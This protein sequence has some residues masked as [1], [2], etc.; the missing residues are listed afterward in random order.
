[1]QK[2]ERIVFTIPL[3]WNHD[4]IDIGLREAKLG[5]KG[6]KYFD[7]DAELGFY[8]VGEFLDEGV[9]KLFLVMI[10]LFDELGFVLDI[11]LEVWLQFVGGHDFVFGLD[12]IFSPVIF[13]F[14][15]FQFLL[16]LAR[17]SLQY[18]IS[19]FHNL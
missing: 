8:F 9:E 13:A 18:L 1:M 2:F 14:P 7:I 5:G 3:L 19:L 17:V 6:A 16:L 11:F 15:L 4:Y 12:L 10:V